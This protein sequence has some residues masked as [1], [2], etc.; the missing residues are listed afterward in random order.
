[1][2]SLNGNW[3]DLVILVIFAYYISEAWR[4]GLWVILADFFAFFLS[5][6]LALRG[7]ALVSGFMRTNFALS[8]SLSNA[9]GYLVVA[10][11]SES[12]LSS[13]FGFLVSKVPEKFWHKPWSKALAILPAL[14][15][16]I[17]LVAF[18][19]TLVMGLPVTPRVKEDVSA[20]KIGGA[21]ITKTTG[22]EATLN[23][24]FGG[25]I[26]DSLTYLTIKPGSK[27]SIPIQAKAD[28]LTV[29]AVSES[30]MFKLVNDE[31]IKEGVGELTW[32]PEL[33]PIARAHA[34]DMWKR[35]YF[36]HY[37]PNGKD[38]GDRLDDAHV[39]YTIAGE[40][41]ALAPTLPTAHNGLMNSPG[42]RANILEPRFKRMGIGVIDNGF[43]GKMFVQIFSD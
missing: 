27:D 42:H 4:V 29:D 36:S 14:G 9:L 43:Y 7:Y 40:N 25:V 38:V 34:E 8:H 15:E 20:S 32:R 19:L 1:M 2:E 30:A 16:G 22:L 41:L 21:I 37:S 6:L 13:A 23:E 17:I 5:L 33:V 24:I 26:E 12:I 18:I 35:G 31:R 39:T 10:G 28:Q 11:A 3:V